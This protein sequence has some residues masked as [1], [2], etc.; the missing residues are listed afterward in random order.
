[1]RGDSRWDPRRPSGGAA[2]AELLYLEYLR[3]AYGVPA[4]HGAWV[5][6][7]ALHYVVARAG[8]ALSRA[9]ARLYRTRTNMARAYDAFAARDAAEPVVQ[10]PANG[11]GL[12][13]ER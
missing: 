7:A 11:L 2:H 9:H 4:L 10:A 3:G 5:E 8:H 12:R 1:L 6:N 13:R